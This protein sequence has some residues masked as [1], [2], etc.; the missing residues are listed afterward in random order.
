MRTTEFLN[1]PHSESVI[2]N[3]NMFKDSGRKREKK[4]RVRLNDQVNKKEFN[5]AINFITESS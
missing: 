3:K 1:T 2:N 5:E 4:K